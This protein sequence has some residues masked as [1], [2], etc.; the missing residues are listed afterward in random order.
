MNPIKFVLVMWTAAVQPRY[1]KAIKAAFQL[2][3]EL[4]RLATDCAVLANEGVG[5]ADAIKQRAILCAEPVSFLEFVLSET[6]AHGCCRFDDYDQASAAF[7]F[8]EATK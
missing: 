5:W 2:N 3:L 1:W 6:Q 7:D 4:D 8:V